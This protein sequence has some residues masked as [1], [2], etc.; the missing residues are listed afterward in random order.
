MADRSSFF[1]DLL[2][3]HI[4]LAPK[5]D[6]IISESETK[7]KKKNRALA[8]PLHD[9]SNK[10]SILFQALTIRNKR[11]RSGLD[12][13]PPRPCKRTPRKRRTRRFRRRCRVAWSKAHTSSPSSR[14][15]FAGLSPRRGGHSSGRTKTRTGR[16]GPRAPPSR[17]Q[18]RGCGKGRK[19]LLAARQMWA[20]SDAWKKV[21]PFR[22][23]LVNP[24]D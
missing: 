10:R 15:R 4:P 9:Y 20:R 7:R 16:I 17:G 2:V 6:L 13:L 8:S 5:K 14:D 18:Q 21:S 22:R 24:I 23:K 3:R 12:F 11:T 19:S 1:R